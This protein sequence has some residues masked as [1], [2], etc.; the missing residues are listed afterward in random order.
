MKQKRLFWSIMGICILIGCIMVVI[1]IA[2]GGRMNHLDSNYVTVGDKVVSYHAEDHDTGS[3][4]VHSSEYDNVK[5][6]DFDLSMGDVSI[7]EGDGFA[8]SGSEIISEISEDG[9]TWK[10]K[11]PKRKWHHW[12]TN[13][14]SGEWKITLPRNHQF[15]RV[16]INFAAAEIEIETIAADTLVIKGG[17]GEADIDI[18][19]V[20]DSLDLQI[21]AGEIQIAG[22]DI[23]GNS[24]IKCGA[25]SLDMALS[26]MKGSVTVD[27][28]MGSIDMDLPGHRKEYTIK[29]QSSLGSVNIESDDSDQEDFQ[30][31]DILADLDLNCAMGEI[32]LD[33]E[34]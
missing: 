15:E 25:G 2:M 16:S 28:G 10:L 9:E 8:I 14:A 23:D 13:H 31:A 32:N 12:F 18:M 20:R 27:C 3:D 17:A 34:D 11:S 24:R 6:L 19:R 4:S 7:V 30:G 33:F 22:G 29:S 5:N 1:G 21:G 26:H